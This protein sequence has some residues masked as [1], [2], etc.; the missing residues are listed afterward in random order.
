MLTKAER[1][2]FLIYGW[3]RENTNK[4]NIRRLPIVLTNLFMAFYNDKIFW[5]IPRNRFK[6]LS[7]KAAYH[8]QQ[9]DGPTIIIYDGITFQLFALFTQQ[10]EYWRQIRKCSLILKLDPHSVPKDAITMDLVYSMIMINGYRDKQEILLHSVTD[11]IFNGCDTLHC[12]Q[13]D[14]DG[15]KLKNGSEWQLLHARDWNLH[16]DI[17]IP[18]IVRY[19]MNVESSIKWK[20]AKSVFGDGAWFVIKENGWRLEL[21]K[22][23][24]I[25]DKY[26]AL[27]IKPDT[28]PYHVDVI[29][30]KYEWKA[31]YRV[32]D[33]DEEIKGNGVVTFYRDNQHWDFNLDPVKDENG[34]QAS[35][36]D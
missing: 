28:Y 9:L 1:K 19:K 4:L 18:V 10:Q 30:I 13:L 35:G 15:W 3:E 27:R 11:Q 33:K 23:L 14:H 34:K 7:E 16:F 32:N 25:C 5:N 31:E 20:M 24:W 21:R 6:E 17:D 36:D 2:E 29:K 8:S 22:S 26:F 12:G